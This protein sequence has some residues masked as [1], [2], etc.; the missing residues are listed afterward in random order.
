FASARHPQY[1]TYVSKLCRPEKA[2]VPELCGPRIPRSDRSSEEHLAFHR[3]MLILF[4]P[5]RTLNDLKSVGQTWTQAFE[6]YSF[7]DH[8]LQIIR[9]I[10][11]E[12]ECRDARDTYESERR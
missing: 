10:H 12:H 1:E 6:S 4:K 7:P 3:V 8:L 2:L 11:I 5:W 9:N